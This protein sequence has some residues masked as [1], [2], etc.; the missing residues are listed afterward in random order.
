M[1]S[2]WLN[3]DRPPDDKHVLW[4]GAGTKDTGFSL[5]QLTFQITHATASD[6]NAER[7]YIVA[8]LRKN[9]V[10]GDVN[11][12]QSGQHLPVERVNHYM[13]DG[14]VMVASLVVEV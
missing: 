13:T 6:A 11:S 8:E 2:F 3:T 12:Y 10:I 14:E 1:P 7:D 9:Q 4:V 5:T